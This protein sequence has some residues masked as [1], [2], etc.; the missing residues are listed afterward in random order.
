MSHSGRDLSADDVREL[1][2]ETG[3]ILA[4][5]GLLAS[6]YVVGGA[7]IAL[8]IDTRR[9]T[10]DI[11]AAIRDH[12]D[13]F[14][15]AAAEV[16]QRHGLNLTWI[17]SDAVGF[18]SNHPLGIEPEIDLPGLQVVSAS[19]EHLLALKIRAARDR[20]F[21]DIV[22]LIRHLGLTSPEQ[23]ADVVNN[24]FGEEDLFWYGP[25]EAL[26]VAQAAFAYAERIGLH[27][28]RPQ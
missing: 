1:L 24:Q 16:A 13:E 8:T 17:N 14:R 5:Q 26:Y 15:A 6:I 22:L 4:D 27:L 23:V 20:D 11:D 21:D 25:E 9:V 3:Q 19:P 7:A 18:L 28:A 2:A 12:P 10:K